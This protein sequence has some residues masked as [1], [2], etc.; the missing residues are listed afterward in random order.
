MRPDDPR[1]LAF[2]A[3]LVG[4]VDALAA[5][6]GGQAS[7]SLVAAADSGL[8]RRALRRLIRDGRVRSTRIG[9]RVYVSRADLAGLLADAPPSGARSTP[10]AAPDAASAARAAY[11][12]PLRVVR[13]SR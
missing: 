13:G 6:R 10:A 12:A 11:A 5:E 2:A 9:R 3:A 7:D 8:E 1:A 4:L